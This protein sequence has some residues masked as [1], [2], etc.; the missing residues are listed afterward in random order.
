[1][2]VNLASKEEALANL[3]V[4]FDSLKTAHENLEVDKVKAISEVK[5]LKENLRKETIV[6]ESLQETN[7]EAIEQSKESLRVIAKLNGK[8]KELESI[9]M[10]T[11]PKIRQNKKI[12]LEENKLEA[13]TEDE[14]VDE[15]HNESKLFKDTFEDKMMR[16]NLGFC[17]QCKLKIP[18]KCSVHTTNMMLMLL[19]INQN[20]VKCPKQTQ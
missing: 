10:S 13:K 1:M 12:N 7:Y 17:S 15:N 16:M 2:K 6:I 5:F 20:L 3:H 4:H 11:S 9:K 19:I 8:I 14:K 18:L